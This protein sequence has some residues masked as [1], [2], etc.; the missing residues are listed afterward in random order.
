MGARSAFAQLLLNYSPVWLVLGLETVLGKTINDYEMSTLRMLIDE[1]VLMAREWAIYVENHA[2]GTAD[3]AMFETKLRRMTLKKFLL[4][5]LFLDKAKLTRLL[6]GNPCLF[7]YVRF[8][9][10]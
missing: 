9:S 1:H 4:L 10:V 5:V 8:Q 2:F 6:P 3:R 7:N